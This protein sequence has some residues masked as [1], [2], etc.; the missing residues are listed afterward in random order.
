MI[1]T[2]QNTGVHARH[3]HALSIV[4]VVISTLLVGMV[5]VGSLSM[6]GASV[7]SREYSSD[8]AKGPLLADA[9]LAEIMSMPYYD[10]DSGSGSNNTNTGE[11]SATRADF[12]DVG[13]Y[14][15]WST[16]TVQDRLGNALSEYA[17]WSRS[18]QVNW[19]LRL[20]GGSWTL[21]DSG[22]K[23]IVVT[24]TSPSGVTTTRLGW[25]SS[26]GSL[27]QSPPTDM[28]AISLIETSLTLGPSSTTAS[29]A[30]NLLNHVEDPNG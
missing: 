26:D 18:V 8:M 27:E 23:R 14:D 22:A 24:V 15:D 1:S 29:G 17:G 11:L 30:T 13:D 5:V 10:P 19:G 25:R 2:K 21:Y 20:T 28:T 16:S 3:R 7:R 9:M 4:E 6:L 12:D